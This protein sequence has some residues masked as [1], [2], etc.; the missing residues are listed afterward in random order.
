MAKYCWIKYKV[1]SEN[2]DIKNKRYS[3]GHHL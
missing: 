1:L 3:T 2:D